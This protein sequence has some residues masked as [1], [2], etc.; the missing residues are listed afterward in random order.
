[1]LLREAA[2][3]SYSSDIS[4]TYL[5]AE[6]QVWGLDLSQEGASHRWL[7]R[8]FPVTSS[9]WD[10]VGRVFSSYFLAGEGWVATPTSHSARGRDGLDTFPSA[11]SLHSRPHPQV[12]SDK[13]EL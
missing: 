7:S 5:K 11:T 4:V 9:S 1:M 8:A 10:E 13:T 6:K 3:L 12:S 2:S